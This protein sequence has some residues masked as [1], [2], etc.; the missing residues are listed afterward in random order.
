MTLTVEQIFTDARSQ[1]GYLDVTVDAETLRRLYETLKWGPT[2]ANSS[3][4]R[5]VFLT[6]PEA[7]ERLRPALAWWV[8]PERHSSLRRFG[9]AYPGFSIA[10]DGSGSWVIE[11]KYFV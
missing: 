2:S 8:P 1:N 6:T 9:L 11:T 4:A 5:F 3:P 7:K 10:Q